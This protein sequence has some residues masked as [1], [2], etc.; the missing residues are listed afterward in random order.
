MICASVRFYG[1]VQGVFFRANTK[2]KAKELG[3]KGWVRNCSDGSVEALFEG[4]EEKVKALVEYCSKNIHGAEVE[5]VD[6]KYE[7]FKNTFK[8]FEIRY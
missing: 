2:R 8:D 3:V 6:I 7:N 5:K 4:D 1:L